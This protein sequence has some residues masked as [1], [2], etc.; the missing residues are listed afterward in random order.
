MVITECSRESLFKEV[1]TGAYD[2]HLRGV[3]IHS[4][5]SCHYWWSKMMA[6]NEKWCDSCSACAIRQ[7]G[8][9]VFP[10][11]TPVSMGGLFDIVRKWERLGNY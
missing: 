2:G 5:L 7:V 8:H 10:P 1:H 6:D 4:Q 11:L 9:K 3:K